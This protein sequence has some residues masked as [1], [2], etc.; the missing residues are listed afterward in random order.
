[1]KV[2]RRKFLASS[3]MAAAGT[4]IGMN[5]SAK[6]WEKNIPVPAALPT[7]DGKKILYTYG[8][9]DG[10]EPKQSVDLFVPWLKSEGASVDGHDSMDAYADSKYMDHL[11]I[12]GNVIKKTTE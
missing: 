10:H 1:M 5:A 3:A 2:T 4:S 8:G 11:R 12:R 7:L 9:W 6:T